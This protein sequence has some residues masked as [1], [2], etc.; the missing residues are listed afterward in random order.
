MKT[1]Y[2]VVRKDRLG[3]H[4]TNWSCPMARKYVLGERA[5]AEGNSMLF[6]YLDYLDATIFASGC[7]G[8]DYYRV[9]LCNTE[10][11]PTPLRLIVCS[12][13]R[14]ALPSFWNDHEEFTSSPPNHNLDYCSAPY[15]TYIVKSLTPIREIENFI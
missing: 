4:S 6:C 12:N 2:K 8:R 10:D 9:L 13:Y 3:Y 14:L 1:V 5:V 11:E 15:G 7:G